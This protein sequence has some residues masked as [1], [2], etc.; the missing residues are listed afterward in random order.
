MGDGDGSILSGAKALESC[1]YLAQ[2]MLA[3]NFR[4][5]NIDL[6]D[7]TRG[8]FIPPSSNEPPSVPAQFSQSS[9]HQSTQLSSQSQHDLH[10]QNYSPSDYHFDNSCTNE[11]NLWGSGYTPPGM[12]TQNHAPPSGIHPGAHMPTMTSNQAYN[13]YDMY[14]SHLHHQTYSSR[15]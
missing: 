1:A 8:R 11:A 7:P 15:H 13:H 5:P 6:N 14:H 2:S 12:I 10:H 9:Q 4:E 3:H